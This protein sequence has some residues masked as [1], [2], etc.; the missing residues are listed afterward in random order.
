MSGNGWESNPHRLSRPDTDFEDQ[1]AHRDLTIP[2]RRIMHKGVFFN[3]F[4]RNRGAEIREPGAGKNLGLGLV[5]KSGHAAR[6]ASGA[7]G[8]FLYR[9]GSTVT[10]W[11]WTGI[12]R[13]PIPVPR[14]PIPVSFYLLSVFGHSG[15]FFVGVRN[16]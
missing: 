10:V 7:I 8:L 9:F 13:S 3:T 15:K 5:Q 14:S 6:F 2:T 4:V 12:D 16:G 11:M 1:E